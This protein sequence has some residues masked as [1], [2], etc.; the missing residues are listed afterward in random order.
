MIAIVLTF[1]IVFAF[2]V[3][4]EIRAQSAERKRVIKQAS[5]LTDLKH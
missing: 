2:A 1:I 4:E 3:G 5:K